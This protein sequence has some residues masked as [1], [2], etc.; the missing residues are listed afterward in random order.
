[1][2]EMPLVIIEDDMDDQEMFASVIRELDPNQKLIFFDR[3]NP[4]FD[5][6]QQTEDQPLLI[7]SD[8]NLPDQSGIEFKTQIDANPYLREKSIPFVF[9]STVVE[10]QAV[11]KAYTELTVQGFFQK[12]ATYSDLRDVF[13]LLLLYWKTCKHPKSLKL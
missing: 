3:C 7:I 12:P 1:M 6:L 13:N 9:L 2:R 8:I 4:A 10:R 5:Y 11:K